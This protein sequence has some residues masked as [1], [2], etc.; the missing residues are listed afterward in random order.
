MNERLDFIKLIFSE[1]K[2]N[3]DY[4]LIV[5]VYVNYFIK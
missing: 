3:F 2:F 1:C 5:I 4:D